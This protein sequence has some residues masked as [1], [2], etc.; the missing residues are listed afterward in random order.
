[1]PAAVNEP[2]KEKAEKPESGLSKVSLLMLKG[3]V[4]ETSLWPK[5]QM[6]P[7]MLVA[8]KL[9]IPDPSAE[10]VNCTVPPPECV[11]E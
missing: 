4:N 5:V 3:G 2:V 11:P 9:A 1:V 10:T 8:V 6:S 7:G